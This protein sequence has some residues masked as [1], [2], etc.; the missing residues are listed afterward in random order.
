MAT[1]ILILLPVCSA[2][3]Y[4]LPNLTQSD[5]CPLHRG[6]AISATLE[7]RD[8]RKPIRFD[9]DAALLHIISLGRRVKYRQIALWRR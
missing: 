9:E 8:F 6:H 2:S 3:I 1:S 4:Y 5:L 7:L